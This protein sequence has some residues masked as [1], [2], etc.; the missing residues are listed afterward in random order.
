MRKTSRFDHRIGA[1]RSALAIAVATVLQP[2]IG[3]EL[4]NNESFL[5]RWDNS[6][7][8]TLGARTSKPSSTF[9]NDINVNDGD[10]AFPKRG[11]VITNRF[12]IL[13]EFDF[14]L[15]DSAKSGLRVSAAGWY[16]AVYRKSHAA[17]DPATYNP[18]SASNTEFTRYARKW[19]GANVELYDGF[20]HSGFD[21]GGHSLAFRLG[22]HTLTWGESLL[23]ANNGIA[24]G[25]AP[26]DVNK[27]LTVPG[28]Q[29]KD[30]LMPVNQL[31]ASLSVSENWD[32][33]GYY[34]LE[35]R[36]TRLPA[37]GTFFSPADVVFDGAER[38]LLAPGFGVP[39]QGTQK[40]PERS[41]QW[42]VA[43]K[44][45]NA[46]T[47]ADYGFYYLRF[48]AKTPQVILQLGGPDPMAPMP[49]NY[50]FVYPQ[51]IDVLGVSTSTL[52]GDANVA[53]EISVRNNMPLTSLN[54]ALVALPGA[55]VDGDR[56]PL[57]AVGRSLHYQVS[58]LWT[59]PRLP[60]WDT[61]TLVAEI[62]GNTLLKTTKN[63]AARNTDTAR[64]SIGL[65]VGFEPTWY[66]AL[67]G[68]NLSL[69]LNLA[70]YTNDKPAAVVNAAAGRSVAVGLNFAYGGANGVKGGIN[71]TKQLGS[72]SSNAFGD[73][74][75]VTLN[76]LYS[77]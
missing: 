9:L 42:G 58:T 47:G 35:Y 57:Y 72:D 61:A 6:L 75:F 28:L 23:L 46:Q 39:L 5:V 50:F 4:V 30:F 49:T 54:T 26:A 10:A 1:H 8:Y 17:I 65:G 63:A 33:A 66:Q 15:K 37:P 45:R 2:A 70:Y 76:V 25:Q 14:T 59:L 29:V 51:K 69:P 32:L 67:P 71:Y 53:G 36:P 41:G 19:N 24:A 11:D 21:I 40:P 12:D 74:D 22:R 7:K 56:N 62:G 73:R 38:L 18:T 27:V 20:V 16:D 3:A 34:Q 77:F 68:L 31:S 13:S 64:T 48:T 60:L 43:A 52:V 44:Y 55:A